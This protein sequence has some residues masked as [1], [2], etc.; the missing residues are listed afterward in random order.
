MNSK[1]TRNV[2]YETVDDSLFDEQVRI[3]IENV[4]VRSV[5]SAYCSQALSCR[6]DIEVQV[7]CLLVVTVSFTKASW[8]ISRI[9]TTTAVGTVS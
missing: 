8:I 6:N 7:S 1:G 9:R 3:F 5:S 2:I 4:S